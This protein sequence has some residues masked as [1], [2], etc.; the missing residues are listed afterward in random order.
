[1]CVVVLILSSSAFSL[2]HLNSG[3]S[4]SSVLICSNTTDCIPYYDTGSYLEVYT[5]TCS[6]NSTL[7]RYGNVILNN[8][9]VTFAQE[10]I[11]CQYGC[12]NDMC[13]KVTQS[14]NYTL[15]A[16]LVIIAL[17]GVFIILFL[18]SINAGTKIIFGGLIAL[19]V[20]TAIFIALAPGLN[21]DNAGIQ[22]IG[23]SIS[24]VYIIYCTVTAFILVAMCILYLINYIAGNKSH[25]G[26]NDDE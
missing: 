24:I 6:S 8:S 18:E 23:N 19:L 4:F 11:V 2:H 10:Q 20:F 7:M 16:I 3:Y 26:D 15:L 12:Q 5:Y 25:T 14:T 1:M 9:N 13:V 17:I 21:Y 22:I